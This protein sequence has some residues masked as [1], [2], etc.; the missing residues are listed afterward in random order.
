MVMIPLRVPEGMRTRLRRLSV[1]HGRPQSYY[2]REALRAM[3]ELYE[4]GG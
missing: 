2:L 3:L 4:G 1:K